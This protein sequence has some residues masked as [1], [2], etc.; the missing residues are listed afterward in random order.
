MKRGLVGLVLLL[1]C[2]PNEPVQDACTA[3]ACT[4]DDSVS[5]STSG[6]ETPASPEV[7]VASDCF[8][9]PSDGITLVRVA[10]EGDALLLEVGHSGGCAEHT[11]RLCADPV[12]LRSEPA[13]QRFALVHDANGDMCEAYLTT[14][15]RVPVSALPH[16]PIDV[17]STSDRTFG[18]SVR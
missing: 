8:D 17:E 2:G 10:L 3:P 7:S 11:Y 15:L 13:V 4:G 16:A 1:A 14:T 5:H 9:A 18:L 6:D 12:L